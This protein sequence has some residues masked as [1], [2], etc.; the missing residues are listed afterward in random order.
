MEHR[1]KHCLISCLRALQRAA[2]P[3]QLTCLA[4]A[5]QFPAFAQEGSGGSRQ[6]QACGDKDAGI[7]LPPD[8]CATVFADNIGHAR[9]MAVAPDGVVYVNTWSGGYYGSSKPPPG[10]FIV[11]LQ[12]TNGDGHADIIK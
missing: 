6:T 1:M 9:H 2:A 11:A 3:L 7:T 10:G 8:F 5:L 4:L 12:D